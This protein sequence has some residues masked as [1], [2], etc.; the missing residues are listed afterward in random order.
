MAGKFTK[1]IKERI[2]DI[3]V[4]SGEGILDDDGVDEVIAGEIADAIISMLLELYER[5]KTK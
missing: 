2:V 5:E 4:M 1:E 3:I